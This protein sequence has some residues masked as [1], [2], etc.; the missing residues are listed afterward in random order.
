MN[1][2]HHY[3]GARIEVS[4]TT[5][6]WQAKVF[7]PGTS[8]AHDFTPTARGPDGEASVLDQAKQLVNEVDRDDEIA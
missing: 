3:K 6:G 4:R 7:L 5:D 8:F 1:T 2:R